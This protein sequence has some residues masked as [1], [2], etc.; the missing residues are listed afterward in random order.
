MNKSPVVTCETSRAFLES[1]HSPEDGIDIN[2]LPDGKQSAPPM[3]TRNGG[4]TDLENWGLRKDWGRG[5]IGPP[6]RREGVLD[7]YGL[8]LLVPSPTPNQ[9]AVRHCTCNC[10]VRLNISFGECTFAWF[11]A[12]IKCTVRVAFMAQFPCPWPRG[13]EDARIRSRDL[14]T[15]NYPVLSPAQ[16]GYR[17]PLLRLPH[18][19]FE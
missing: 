13:S 11:S 19:K 12:Q 15:K 14:L 7:S 3:D 10:N 9:A 1:C 4:V 16:G 2:G 6:V 18:K 5:R 8:K 17:S